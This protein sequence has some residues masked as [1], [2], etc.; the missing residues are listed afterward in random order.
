MYVLFLIEIYETL[1]SF[2]GL[3]PHGMTR[4]NYTDYENI[5]NVINVGQN[6]LKFTNRLTCGV[7]LLTF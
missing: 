4:P 3:F 2:S 1:K 5:L 7:L 6:I